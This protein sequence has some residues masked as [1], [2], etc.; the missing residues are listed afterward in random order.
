M[1][2]HSSMCSLSSADYDL[3][4]R[5]VSAKADRSLFGW[6]RTVRRPRRPHVEEAEVVPLAAEA[7]E[8]PTGKLNTGPPRL[9]DRATPI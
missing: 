1:M 6:L 4:K 5:S 2:A 8:S 9:P 3:Y 7:A